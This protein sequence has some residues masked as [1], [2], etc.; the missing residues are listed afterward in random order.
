MLRMD[1]LGKNPDQLEILIG[2]KANIFSNS[3]CCK[4][5]PEQF[6]SRT[7]NLPKKTGIILPER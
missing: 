2:N 1:L 6:L 7:S 4:L 3:V 5:K